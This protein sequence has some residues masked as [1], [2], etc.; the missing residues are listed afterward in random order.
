MLSSLG[1]RVF[2]MNNVH[3][4]GPV[5]LESRWALSY[6]CGPLTRVQVKQLM[7]AK[8]GAAEQ[9]HAAPAATSARPATAVASSPAISSGGRPVLPPQVAQYFL[10]VRSATR[11][12]RVWA[13]P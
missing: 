5:L 3:E 9:A 2:L 12:G 6:L 1:N 13:S 8:R 7:D 10:P 4:N 11:S